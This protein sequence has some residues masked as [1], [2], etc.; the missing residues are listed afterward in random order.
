MSSC[1]A[2]HVCLQKY[3]VQGGTLISHSFMQCSKV[4]KWTHWMPQHV[5]QPPSLCG[6]CL[7]TGII[8][9]PLTLVAVQSLYPCPSALDI[10]FQWPPS[11][12]SMQCTLQVRPS[13]S[14]I[15][16]GCI[17]G[18]ASGGMAGRADNEPVQYLVE[19]CNQAHLVAH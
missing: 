2:P 5:K 6:F 1:P 14:N 9:P 4:C 17:M 18:N 12:P 13:P 3:S 15:G 7:W 8:A 10:N 11:C 16:L 19:C